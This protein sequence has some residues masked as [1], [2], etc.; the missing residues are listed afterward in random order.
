MPWIVILFCSVVFP[1][2]SAEENLP[3]IVKK[4]EPSTVVILTYDKEGKILGQGSGF[5]ISKN[6]DVITNRHVLQGASRAEVKITNE[7]HFPITEVV[8]EDKEGDL[9]RISVDIPRNSVHPLPISD[10]LPEVGE[11]V[12]VI[13]SPLG[14]ERT[15]TDGIVSAVREIPGFGKIIQITAPV[16]LGSS[17]SPV[18]NMKGE[19]IGVATFLILEGQNL[20]FAIP[21]ERVL[22]LVPGKKQTLAEWKTKRDEEWLLSA[23]GLYSTGLTFLWIEDY[24]NALSYFEQALKKDPRHADACVNVGYCNGKLGRY[25]EAI[26][27]YKQAI[28][29]KPDYADA[30]YNLGVTYGELG[31]YSEAIKAYKQTIRIKPD[32]ARA[33]YNLGVAYGILGRYNEAIKVYKQAVR[34]KPDFAEA[35]F[36]LGAIY[37][38]LGRY[39]EAIKA[40]KQ[41]IRIK[42]DFA[43]AHCNLGVAYVKLGRYNEAIEAYKQAVRIKPD[44]DAKAHCNLGLA[45][46][47]LGRYNEAIETYK[48]AIRIK[49][50]Y[51]DAH[52]AL[53]VTYLMLGNKG[54]ALDQYRIL[55]DLN[56]DLANQLFDLIYK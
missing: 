28:R 33:H 16:S 29:I 36:N 22:K 1:L 9:I 52:F 32:D 40:Y 4:I 50:D 41:A 8:A 45:Y 19:V 44:D 18:V 17:G 38:E 47:V 14:L 24:K 7:R 31:R 30:H 15:V 10:S 55:K 20:N 43:R 12:L 49:S 13:G 2:S 56:K 37:G 34:I 48:Q 11:K 23:E 42:S 6:G 46:G 51:A 35:H 21:G 25:N 3:A 5:F 39:N 53:G 27:A 26:K 54:S